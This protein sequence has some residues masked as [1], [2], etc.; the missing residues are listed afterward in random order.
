MSQMGIQGIRRCAAKGA[1]NSEGR[2]NNR[3]VTKKD[4][5][6][7]V[8]QVTAAVKGTGH[9]VDHPSVRK[10]ALQQSCEGRRERRNVVQM[11]R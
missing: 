9:H 1:V 4:G 6:H 2:A 11:C 7:Q 3:A 10:I 5:L 8:C